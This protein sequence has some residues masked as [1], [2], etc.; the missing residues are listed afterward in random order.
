MQPR[1][2]NC[3]PNNRSDSPTWTLDEGEEM[4]RAIYDLQK[5]FVTKDDGFNSSYVGNNDGY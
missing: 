2:G 5:N 3:T 4:H 1:K